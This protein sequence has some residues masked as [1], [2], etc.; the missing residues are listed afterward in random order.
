MKISRFVLLLAVAGS[1]CAQQADYIQQIKNKP[2]LDVREYRWSRT[3]GIGAAGGAMVSGFPAA[4]TVTPCPRGLVAGRSIYIS[5]SGTPEAV[6]ITGGTCTTGATTTGSLSFTPANAHSGVWVIGTATAGIQEAIG[7]AGSSGARIRIPEGTSLVYA[8]IDVPYSQIAILGAGMG[9]TLITPTGFTTQ[10]LFSFSAGGAQQY[11][12]VRDLSV[13]ASTAQ[14]G[15][16]AFRVTSQ[17]YFL[18]ERLFIY[19]YPSGIWFSNAHIS[20]LSDVYVFD[21]ENATGVGVLVEGSSSFVGRMDRLVVQANNTPGGT[22]QPIAGLRIRQSADIIIRD[23]HFIT[24]QYGLLMDPGAGMIASSVKAIASYF[25]NSWV[26]GVKIAPAAGGAVVRADFSGSWFSDAKGGAGLDINDG[27]GGAIDGVTVHLGQ[28]YRNSGPGLLVDANG[29]GS[30]SDVRIFNS[31]FSGNS[32]GSSGTYPGALFNASDWMFSGNRSGAA[33]GYLNSQGYGLSVYPSTSNNYTITDN[34]FTSNTAGAMDDQGTGTSKVIHSNRGI[35]DAWVTL[36]SASTITLAATD[37]YYI[38]GTT[39]I[40]AIT[41]GYQGREVTFIF[42]NAAPAGVSTGG[43][44]AHGS[45][46]S[47]NIPLVGRYIN[48]QWYFK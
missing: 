3:K 37:N 22:S 31:V 34:D 46:A 24:C 6:S 41:G 5:G 23:S 25:D 1:T 2:E 18:G 19:Q 11:N 33:D 27:A 21:F 7:V 26:E 30:V 15:G 48:S 8:T 14:T 35:D 16:W 45:A 40:T 10:D 20:Q 4:I 32:N 12:I 47:Q 38:N 43:S 36:A 42:L 29:P 28:F 17:N 44:I 9:M 13:M 39:P